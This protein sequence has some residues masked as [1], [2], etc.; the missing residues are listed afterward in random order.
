MSPA[1]QREG[2]GIYARALGRNHD[3][4]TVLSVDAGTDF[5]ETPLERLFERR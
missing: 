5:D 1:I 4:R 2:K 3:E